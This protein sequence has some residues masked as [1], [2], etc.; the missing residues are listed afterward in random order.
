MLNSFQH[1]KR[2][3]LSFQTR[4]GIFVLLRCRTKFGMTSD[5]FF[6]L[7]LSFRTHLVMLNS[8]Q[9]LT[10]YCLSIQPTVVMLNSF[11]HLKRYPLSFQTRFG[12]YVLLRCRT[13]FGMTSDTFFTLML[14]FR[15][16]LV[17]LNSFQH[18]TQYC[19]SIQPPVVMLNSF[20]YLIQYPLSFR[21]CF[22][23]YL[24]E[25]L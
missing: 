11:Q 25:L 5:T 12:I 6:T 10:Q 13:K 4:F 1:L 21:T 17:M 24:N 23:I 8:F 19:L 7:M 16:H 3:T 22:G 9:H 15:T 20:K 2:Y 14:S 18:L